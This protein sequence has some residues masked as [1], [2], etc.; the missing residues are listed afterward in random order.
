MFVATD[1][2]EPC[3]GISSFYYLLSKFFGYV[4]LSLNLP[5]RLKTRLVIATA[6]WSEVRG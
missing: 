5:Q 3:Q 4:I 1:K 2:D 6:D